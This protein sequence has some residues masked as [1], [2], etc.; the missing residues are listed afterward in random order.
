MKL[1]RRNKERGV[2]LLVVIVVVAVFGAVLN[3]FQ[4]HSTIEMEAAA[5]ARDRLRAE[6]LARAGMQLGHL[7]I[8]VQ[9]SV[10]DKNRQ[11][12]GDIQLAEFAPYLVKAFGGGADERA[13]IGSMLGVDFSNL[14]GLGVGKGASFDLDM[15]AEDGK[16]NINCGGGMNDSA[17]QGILFGVLSA[18]F[19]PPAYNT[20]FDVQDSDGQISS[21]EDVAKAIVDWAD[22]DEQRYS[23]DG[24]GGGAEDYRYDTGRDPYRAHNHFYDTLEEV[25]LVRGVG[26]EFWGT[27]GEMLT[28]YGGCK[29]NASA[30]TPEHWPLMA[31]ILRGTV[32]A[33]EEKNPILQSD[34]LMQEFAQ[35]VLGMAKL[36]GGFQT[37]NQFIQMVTNPQQALNNLAQG[38]N[39]GGSGNNNPPPSSSSSSDQKGLPLDPAKVGNVLTVGARRIWRLDS[40]GKIQRTPNRYVE[41]HI[42][43]IWD[44]AHF[45]QNTTST[46]VNDRVGTWVY[47]RQE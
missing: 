36:T 11:F 34:Q 47:W 41:V 19:F 1:S 23:P 14:K 12:V 28:V 40:T 39:N 38:Q 5:N 7:L 32:K 27:F 25:N 10:L 3:D 6:Y 44:G 37:V 46:D 26:D 20:L 15:A 45:N 16:L 43:G 9:A 22:I 30:I 2:A 13:G 31:A 29:V 21:R 4:Y 33:G 24:K 8:K 17:R 18:M 35:Q 42:R